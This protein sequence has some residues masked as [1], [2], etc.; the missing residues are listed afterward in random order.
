MRGLTLGRSLI[1]IVSV[2]VGATACDSGPKAGEEAVYWGGKLNTESELTKRDTA[3]N[4][5]TDLKDKKALPSLYEALKQKGPMAELRPKIAELIGIVGDETSVGPLVDAIDWSA[6]AGGA[7]KEAKFNANTNEKVAKALGKLAK[8][9]DDKAV[10]SLKRLADNN[11]QDV[12]LAAVVAL[13]DIKAPGAVDKLIE[14]ADGHPNN[15]MVKN[16]QIALGKIGDPKSARVLGKLLFFE[17]TGVSFYAD[18]SYELFLLGKPA[19]PVLDEI[20]DG[21]F[22][23]IEELHIDPQV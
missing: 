21:K 1:F 15:F 5:L 18:A 10:D 9:T 13:G 20:Y 4:H 23:E 8:G 2:V 16:A 22:K 3:L 6:G 7:G 19:L 11:S 14:I 12:Q 17:R